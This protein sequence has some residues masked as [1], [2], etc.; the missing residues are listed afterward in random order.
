MLGL[1]RPLFTTVEE[2]EP[3]LV[4][5]VPVVPPCRGWLVHNNGLCSC[6]DYYPRERALRREANRY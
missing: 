1:L 3:P 5:R 4:K 2:F 6:Y